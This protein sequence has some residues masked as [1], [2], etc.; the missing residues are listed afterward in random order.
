MRK[1]IRKI[2]NELNINIVGFTGNE[3]LYGL[4]GILETR[5]GGGLATEFEPKSV[6]ERTDPSITLKDC[7]GIIT[8]AVP[9]DTGFNISSSGRLRGSISKSSWGIDYHKVLGKMLKELCTKL[10]EELG[11]EYLSFADTGPLV[12]RELAYR[13]GL[14]YY[15]KNCCIITP[16]YGSY[17]FIGYILT[18]LE[19]SSEVMPIESQCGD[20]RLCLDACPTCALEAPGVLNPKKCISYLTQTK[21]F[22]PAELQIKM[23]VKIYG[24]DTCQAV[25]PKNKGVNLSDITE[26][27][28]VKT[29]GFVDIE[30]LLKMS[31]N[32]YIKKYGDMAGNWR[33]R[34]VLIRNALIAIRN[35]EME[36][37]YME[38]LEELKKREVE[39]WKPYL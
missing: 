19:L 17:V 1:I 26:F 3:P 11:G 12:D 14:G 6:K 21:D 5:I 34:S 35:M 20:C 36:S 10:K 32:E 25:C 22:I 27:L 23:G 24:C 15:G 9:Y 28:P 30:E 13:S 38:Q 16:G 2:A 8:I 39:L 37:S 33:G 7:K 29:G 18:S 31:K 4:Q